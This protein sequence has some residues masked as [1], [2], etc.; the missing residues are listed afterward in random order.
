M[1]GRARTYL[2]L[3][4]LSLANEIVAVIALSGK[5]PWYYRYLV[6]KNNAPR[7]KHRHSLIQARRR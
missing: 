1:L 5:A 6:S 4:T 2:S 7:F 3:S